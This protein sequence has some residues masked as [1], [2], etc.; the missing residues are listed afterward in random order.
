[1]VRKL[2][3]REF[4]TIGLVSAIIASTPLILRI[5]N[6]N[7]RVKSPLSSKEQVSNSN[8]IIHLPYLTIYGKGGEFTIMESSNIFMKGKCEAGSGTCGILEAMEYLKKTFGE[9]LVFLFGSFYPLSSPSIPQGIRIDGNATL[10]LNSQSVPL[11]I[12]LLNSR[13]I[14]PRIK[15]RWYTNQGKINYILSRRVS[16]SL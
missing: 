3:R 5:D 12:S 15:L 11:A 6:N 4:I 10:F 9:G 2:T 8:S 1:M 14:S 7:K 13:I 16:F